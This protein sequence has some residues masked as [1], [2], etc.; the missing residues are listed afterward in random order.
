MEKEAW[1]AAVHSVHPVS[2]VCDPMD[3]PWNSPGQNT[4]VG[5]WFLLQGIFTTQGSNPGLLLGRQIL[6]QL[7]YPGGQ[8]INY[9]SIKSSYAFNG[10]Y[11]LTR[12]C[13]GKEL[14]CQCGFDPWVG[15]IPW[16][17]VWQPTPVFLPEKPM[18]R[19]V[20]RATA[21]RL[22]KSRTRLK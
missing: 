13:S 11:L 19:G 6:Y 7:S 17:R 1:H 21:H 14:T 3:C 9:T 5:S 12:W 4:G 15:K 18:D 2:T 10:F 16:R 8:Y 20:W 22:A